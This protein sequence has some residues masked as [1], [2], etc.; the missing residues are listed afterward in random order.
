[1]REVILHIGMHKTGTTSIQRSLHKI[2]GGGFR[3]I[4]FQEKNHSIPLKTI[5]SEDRLNYHIWK[6]QGF[7]DNQIYEKK[8]EYENILKEDLIDDSVNVFL[9]SGEDASSLTENE[10]QNLCEFF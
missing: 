9:L 8:A 1:M 10:Q 2:N 5:F 6:N 4:R 3:T 7:T